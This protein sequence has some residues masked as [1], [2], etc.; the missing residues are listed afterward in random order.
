[1]ELSIKNKTKMITKQQNG[2]RIA[3]QDANI[4]IMVVFWFNNLWQRL[5]NNFSQH[6][7]LHVSFFIVFL[8]H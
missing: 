1:M 4:L 3:R 7:L 8:S 2:P 6:L 5:S